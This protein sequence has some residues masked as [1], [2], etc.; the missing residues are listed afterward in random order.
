[1]KCWICGSDADSGEHVIKASDLKAVFGVITQN[2]PIYTHTRLRK[3]Q[4]IGGIKSDRF[5]YGAL[6]CRHCN[7]VRTQPHDRAWEHLSNYLR[8]RHPPI[9]DGT[10]IDLDKVFP[11]AVTQSMLGVHLYFV[12]HFGCRIVEHSVPLDVQ[13]FADAIL[14]GVA[15]PKVHLA[16]WAHPPRRR[17]GL[18]KISVV[19]VGDT[20]QYAGWFYVID[21]IAVNVV[22]LESPQR[23]KN[24]AHA[25]HPSTV[26]KR[27]RIVGLPA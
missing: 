1:M 17:A 18:T 16:F 2:K 10:V 26:C 13:P 6:I 11:R 12:K 24:L 20:L 22:Y 14:R 9:V 21:R 5:K 27:V 15:H 8:S 7:N 25:W 3:N 23:R 19:K 4:P